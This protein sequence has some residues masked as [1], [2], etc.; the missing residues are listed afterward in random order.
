MRKLKLQIQL[1]IDGFISGPNGEM[2]WMIWNWD[3]QLKDFVAK[4]T[5]ST[6]TIILGRKLA[7]GFIPHWK[8]NK[9]LE[10][11][12]KINNSKKIV[13]TKTLESTEWENTILEKGD[14]ANKIRELKSSAGNDI[15]AYGGGEFVS[16]L[17]KEN[18]IDEYYFFINPS[19]LGSGMPIFQ[20]ADYKNELKLKKA[21]AYEC[22]ITVLNYLS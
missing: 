19:I 11:A 1:S 5:E 21:K 22:G 6:D 13:F 4:L 10:G 9:D 18:L 14:L 3:D 12:D 16:S 17:I 20:K 15:I 7:E 2:D 8:S